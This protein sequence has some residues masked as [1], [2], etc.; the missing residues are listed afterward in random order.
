YH[1]DAIFGREK[2]HILELEHSDAE[3]DAYREHVPHLR[4]AINELRG[5]SS[6]GE[7]FLQLAEIQYL[8]LRSQD[9]ALATLDIL[10][11]N[12]STASTDICKA[13]LLKGDILLAQNLP[14][15]ALLLYAQVEK[16]FEASPLGQEARY[17]KARVAFYTG[18]FEWA[19]SQFDVLKTST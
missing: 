17:R 1:K 9:S 6:R 14:Y 19:K 7:L 4:N 13:K 11:K 18:H 12:V 2:V 3:Q 16:E 10:L 8:R 5:H 15:D